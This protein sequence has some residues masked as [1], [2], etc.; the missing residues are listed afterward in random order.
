MA[1]IIEDRAIKLG[2][3]V[4]EAGIYIFFLLA[5]VA[6][7]DAEPHASALKITLSLEGSVLQVP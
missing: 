3:G 1:G 4:E 2:S 7:F 5:Q 6:M